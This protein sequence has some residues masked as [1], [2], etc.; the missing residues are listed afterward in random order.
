MNMWGLDLMSWSCLIDSV[1]V[2]SDAKK[3]EEEDSTGDGDEAAESDHKDD[4]TSHEVE[5]LHYS[6]SDHQYCIMFMPHMFS[7]TKTS[8]LPLFTNLLMKTSLQKK[9]FFLSVFVS[10]PV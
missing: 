9:L 5:R 1:F 8:R 7:T 6:D 2:S 4:S 10:F 3:S